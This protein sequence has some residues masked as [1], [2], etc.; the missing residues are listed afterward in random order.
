MGYEPWIA[1]KLMASGGGGF[2]RIILWIATGAVGL[3]VAVMI[4]SLALMTGFKHE[5]T[6][7]MFGFWGHIHISD[8]RSVRSYEALPFE[9]DST[10]VQNIENIRKV[11]YTPPAGSR[12]GDKVQ[13][14]E[15][16]VHHVQAY[17]YLPGIITHDEQL[18]GIVLKGIGKD[19]DWN[20]INQ[21]RVSDSTWSSLAIDELII[22]QVTATRLRLNVG[23]KLILHFIGKEQQLQRRF[24]IKGIYKT[25]LEENDSKFALASIDRV[26]ELLGWSDT[27]VSGIEISIEN[28]ADLNLITDYIYQEEIPPHL[29]AEN[30]KEKFPSL[31]EW[32]ELQD[33]N[34]IVII[35]LMLAVAIINMITAL[36]I[37]ILE[38]T[39]MIGILKSMGARDKSIRQVFLWFA[40][41]I[42]IGG[43][44]IGNVLGL[45]LVLLEDKY[46]FIKLNEADYYLNYAPVMVMPWHL[47]VVNI[48]ALLLIGICLIAPSFLVSKINPI[49]TIHFN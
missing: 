44:L 43:I 28:I 37:L 16:G 22:S 18:E 12:S 13:T 14:S 31:F 30:I 24:T 32:L 42:T 1:R 6:R 10:L 33:I 34:T 48:G 36:L 19:Y 26:R 15:G 29:Y 47:L 41:F 35:G 11:D 45:G 27:Q 4:V 49:K 39:Q 25:G 7:K 9:Y 2:T 20:S 8:P 21:F 46:Q 5:I 23:D 38:R 40:M 17:I 3:S